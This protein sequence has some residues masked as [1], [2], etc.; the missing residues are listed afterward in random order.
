MIS[1]ADVRLH[2]VFWV[3]FVLIPIVTGILQ[4]DWLPN[5]LFDPE[6]HTALRYREVC[7]DT[8]CEETPSVWKH[9]QSGRIYSYEGFAAHR[10]NEAY[11]M[12]VWWFAY[13][14]IGCFAWAGFRNRE[15]EPDFWKPFSAAVCV[16]AAVTGFVIF[17]HP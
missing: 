5:E 17:I 8:H 9:K 4:Y 7:D 1:L 12:A 13:G 11:R 10:K 14:L 16:N 15:T 3:A 2:K 6:R